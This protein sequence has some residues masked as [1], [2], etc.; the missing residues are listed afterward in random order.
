[1]ATKKICDICGKIFGEAFK[2]AHI[3]MEYTKKS[4]LYVYYECYT[5][6]TPL[7]EIDICPECLMERL[8]NE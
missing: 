7:E 5:N 3:E 1:M 6:L 8:K 4:T 2:K